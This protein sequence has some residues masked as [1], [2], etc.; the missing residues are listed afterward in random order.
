LQTSCDP[1]RRND[2]AEL[3]ADQTAP[4]LV[5]AEIAQ[6]HDG[7]LG[8]AHAFVDLAAEC[9]VDAVKFQTHIASAESSVDEPW[10][11]HFS[12]QD[13]SRYDYWQRTSFT[14]AQWQELAQHAAERSI[15]FLSSAF[16]IEAVELLA[17]LDMPA[18]KVASGEVTN[19]PLLQ[20]MATS[21]KPL[22]ISTG[23]VNHG[24]IEQAIE[25]CRKSSCSY[26]LFQCTSSYPSPPEAIGL[27]QIQE[28]ADRYSCPIGLSDHSGTIFPGLAAVTLGARMLEVHLTMSRHAFGPD[29]PASLTPDQLSDLVAG[30][31]FVHRALQCPVDKD[32]V[33]ETMAPMRAL[34]TQSVCTTRPVACGARLEP[35]DLTTRKP[36]TGIPAHRLTS[37]LGQKVRR[38]LTANHFLTA[39]DLVGNGDDHA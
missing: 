3:I 9:G 28:L 26:A 5:I 6:A 21:G 38:E 25:L 16:S 18:F 19:S 17:E 31:Q 30:S 39:S 1:R 15:N 29:V 37:L 35:G 32:E 14:A 22:L 11:V 34:F 7:S 2:W 8:Q 10:R 36:G 27:N 23:M 4:P 33:A 20:A 12:R 24:E 13:E